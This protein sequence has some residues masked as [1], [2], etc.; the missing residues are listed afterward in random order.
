ML[1]VLSL[2]LVVEVV[3]AA[4]FLPVFVVLENM[5]LYLS[6]L[7][8]MSVFVLNVRGNMDGCLPV[9]P[10]VAES[11]IDSLRKSNDKESKRMT[12]AM[13][14]LRTRA[15]E[16]VESSAQWESN[17]H[18]A[19]EELDREIRLH[20]EESLKVE[21]LNGELTATQRRLEQLQEV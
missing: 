15:D 10:Q 7:V 2:V 20:G 14:E 6:L 13:Q 1:L 4:V 16:L 3:V 12:E 5:L 8:R 11:S 18:R 19:K 9:H 17:Y 21:A